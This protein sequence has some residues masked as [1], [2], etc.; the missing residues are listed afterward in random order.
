MAPLRALVSVDTG[1]MHL[2]DALDVPL[3]A[4]YGAG[5][6]PLWAPSAPRSLALHRQR[7]PDYEPVHPT[8]LGIARGMELMARHS[9]A[10]VIAALD[11][12][13]APDPPL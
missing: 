1:P 13:T 4:L 5:C 9:V 12:V 3:V 2:A 7:D 10:D 8:D 6:L 11:T